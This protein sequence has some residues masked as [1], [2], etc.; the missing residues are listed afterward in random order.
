MIACIDVAFFRQ[1]YVDDMVQDVVDCLSWVH[2]NVDKYGGDKVGAAGVY[3]RLV[4]R[5]GISHHL[6]FNFFFY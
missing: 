4:H 5:L 3:G 2:T 6:F 1:G